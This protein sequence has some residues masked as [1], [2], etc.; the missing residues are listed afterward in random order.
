MLCCNCC[1]TDEEKTRYTG[2]LCGLGWD[3]NSDEGDSAYPDHDMEITFDWSFDLHDLQLVCLFFYF[4]QS[5]MLNVYI[6][7]SYRFVV[8]ISFVR[9]Q[10]DRRVL[11]V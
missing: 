9:R 3:V 10:E 6:A 2:A 11:S 8:L 1:R 5:V 4:K 7:L